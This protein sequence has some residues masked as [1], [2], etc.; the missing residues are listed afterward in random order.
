M[1]TGPEDEPPSPEEDRT[2]NRLRLAAR[3]LS[4]LRAGG[5]DVDRELRALA[6]AHSAFVK[7]DTRRA[8]E[9]VDA[10]FAELD[11]LPR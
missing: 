4:V 3:L 8:G 11:R 2:A 9:L 10:L 6:A 1:T 5:A 7:G